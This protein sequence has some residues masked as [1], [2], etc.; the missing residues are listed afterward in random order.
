MVDVLVQDMSTTILAKD[1]IGVIIVQYCTLVFA[2]LTKPRQR[3]S[4]HTLR[5]K[6]TDSCRRLPQT[7]WQLS[8]KK[9]QVDT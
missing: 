2:A 6:V 3:Q 9:G 4:A 1:A 8:R 5:H 7:A